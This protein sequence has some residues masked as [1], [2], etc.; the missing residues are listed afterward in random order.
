MDITWPE[1]DLPVN[2][3]IVWCGLVEKQTSRHTVAQ[4]LILEM[5][6]SSICF[7]NLPSHHGIQK[8]CDLISNPITIEFHAQWHWLRAVCLFFARA[9]GPKPTT[10]GERR[11]LQISIENWRNKV[12]VF[13]Q[14]RFFY[15]PLRRDILE[16]EDLSWTKIFKIC[17]LEWLTGK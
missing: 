11:E 10:R 7:K 6:Y 9:Q 17:E 1:S 15:V 2:W 3:A 16:G 4:G 14:S 5:L 8:S 13:Q 12:S